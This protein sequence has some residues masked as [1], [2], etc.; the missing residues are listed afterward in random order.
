MSQKIDELIVVQMRWAYLAGSFEA[1]ATGQILPM[2]K[3]ECV[4][5]HWNCCGRMQE[6][7]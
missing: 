7:S 2:T 3:H 5:L 6:H 4:V 1:V